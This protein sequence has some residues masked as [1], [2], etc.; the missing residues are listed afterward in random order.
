M[1]FKEYKK[2]YD[3]LIIISALISIILV[4][5][6]FSNTIILSQH[7]YNIIDN[8]I[9]IIF[10]IDYFFRLFYA[11]SK[12]DFFIRNIFDLLAILPLD[13]LFSFF[14]IARI[15]RVT[16]V[17]RLAR[18]GRV[19]GI[20]GKLTNKISDFLKINGFVNILYASLILI[21]ISSL[22]YSYAENVPLIE[23]VWWALVTATTVGYGDISPNTMLGKI[24]AILLM[25]LGIG[26]IGI[27]TSTITEYFNRSSLQ[28]QTTDTDEK[29]DLL[30]KKMEVLEKEIEELKNTPH[31]PK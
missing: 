24:S 3:L 2:I 5:L 1:N 7:P 10:S 14:R 9:L 17:S 23:A 11:T 19:I 13:S 4:V 27:L 6:D 30:L 29:L 28:K 20:T 8:T 12:K 18:L 21:V 15:V 16:R 22:T 25:L 26:F 31:H